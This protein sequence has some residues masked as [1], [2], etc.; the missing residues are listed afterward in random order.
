[1]EAPVRRRNGTQEVRLVAA[2]WNVRLGRISRLML[3]AH[4]TGCYCMASADTLP[5]APAPRKT[6]GT[7][8]RS[9]SV[10]ITDQFEGGKA[11][12]PVVLGDNHFQLTGWDFRVRLTNISHTPA[13]ARVSCLWATDGA[14]QRQLYLHCLRNGQWEDIHARESERADAKLDRQTDA[15]LSLDAGEEIY[16]VGPFW[17]PYSR[18]SAWLQEKAKLDVCHVSSIHR[19]PDGRDMWVATIT[20]PAVPEAEKRRLLLLGTP[21]VFEWGEVPC[22]GAIEFL[23]GTDARAAEI[24]KRWVVDVIPYSDP[25]AAVR[26]DVP[27]QLFEARAAADG[28]RD[29]N[30]NMRALW[31][32]IRQHVPQIAIE[33]HGENRLKADGRHN[34][35]YANVAETFEDADRAALSDRVRDALIALPDGGI[36]THLTRGTWHETL[37]YALAERLGTAAFLY[38]A[39]QRY[40]FQ[41]NWSRGVGALIAAVEAAEL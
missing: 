30:P 3:A 21:Q 20:D 23:C 28:K 5:G 36:R 4:L 8:L 16:L 27:N 34:R 11:D 2:P 29:C 37:A 12:R 14:Q 31:G 15:E 9:G 1:M 39:H 18:L 25:D 13:T 19:T 26:A 7:T 17:I 24:R 33:F 40:G 6:P 10:V 38:A 32:W 41:A 35:V 22:A